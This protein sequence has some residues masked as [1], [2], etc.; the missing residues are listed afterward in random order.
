MNYS[1]SRQEAAQEIVERDDAVDMLISF[2]QYTLPS[3]APAKHHYL[4]AEKLEAV[5]R[6]EI[7]RLMIF[8]PP[9]HGKSELG[10]KRFPAWYLGRNPTKQIITAS[11]AS[12]L[13]NDFGREVRNIVASEEYAALF[14]TELR[15]DSK[16]AN[17]WHTSDGG[18]YVAAGVGTATTGRG[19]DLGLIDD[20]FKD[21]EDAD[22]QLKR[23][24]VWN[25]YQSTFYTRLMPGAAVILIN[26]RWHDDD[27]SG[28][29][30]EEQAKGGDQWEI[31]ELPA[32]D[33]DDNALWPEWYDKQA[34]LR[35]KTAIGTREWSALY[36]QKPQPDDGTF[37]QREWFRWYDPDNQPKHLNKYLSSDFAVTEDGG[38]FTELGVFGVS[39]A[40][41]LYVLDWWSGQTTADVWI[42]SALDL[43]KQHNT[44]AM[45]GE[46]GSIR[47]SIEPFL[48][49]RIRERRIYSRIEWITRTRDKA[50]SARAFQARCAMGKVYLP[51]N[52]IGEALLDQ[53]LRFPT[54]KHDDKVDVCALMGMVLDQAHPAIAQTEMEDTGIKDYGLEP[55]DE[56]SW[57]TA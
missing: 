53:L 13:A 56:D 41:D 15:Q 33:A 8:M 3:Y 38:D 12:D 28:R 18:V 10:S 11:Y 44:L 23:D 31:L 43:I 9:R 30:L 32:I 40:D 6:G 24:K 48:V 34:L 5:E 46:S 35:I 36:Q 25:W 17:R 22:S 2:T 50:T 19:A 37:F 49:K 16:A 51:K 20:P 26:T 55:E 57:K 4:I 29:L 45:F 27:L 52:D 39:A 7:D 1:R 54:A 47:R 14:D 42:D 21:R